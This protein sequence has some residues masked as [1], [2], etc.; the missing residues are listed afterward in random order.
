[1]AKKSI[2]LIIP[3]KD[4][5]ETE[6]LNIKNVFEK[7]NFTLFIASDAQALCIGNQGL[8]VRADVSFFNM[9]ESNFAA[10]IFIGGKGVTSYWNN[11]VLH[12]IAIEFQ[13]ARKPVAAICAAPVILAKAGLL[14][15]K[16][17]TC[18][19]SVRKDIEREGVE[20]VE[21]PIVVSGN[22]ITAQGPAAVKEFSIAIIEQLSKS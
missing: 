11:F 21:S 12:N 14:D 16:P 9:H 5:N 2:L 7:S 18:F 13:K 4:F 6:Y 17:A 19:D 15:N 1:M 3:A 20:Y 8:K 10:V 22:I